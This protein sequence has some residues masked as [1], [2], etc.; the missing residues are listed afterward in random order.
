MLPLEAHPCS[1]FHVHS[2]LCTGTRRKKVHS[3]YM[4]KERLASGHGWQ[5][6]YKAHTAI[7]LFRCCWADLPSPVKRALMIG[8]G[9]RQCAGKI[10][11]Q[12]HLLLPVNKGW[13]A[14]TEKKGRIK[15]KETETQDERTNT[16][17]NCRMVELEMEERKK[18]GRSQNYKLT[19]T[20]ATEARARKKYVSDTRHII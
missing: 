18:K 15:E 4:K 10:L 12:L 7:C 9:K 1:Y 16:N 6:W 14:N 8:N 19:K 2:L 5:Q 17:G 13:R 3:L 20:K 11:S